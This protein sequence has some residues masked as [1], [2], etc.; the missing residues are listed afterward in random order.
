MFITLF[1]LGAC[2]Q[3]YVAPKSIEMALRGFLSYTLSAASPA[4]FRGGKCK[5]NSDCTQKTC[6]GTSTLQTQCI[7]GDCVCPNL[8]YFHT[9]LDPGLQAEPTPGR[10]K[11]V[12]ASA[13]IWTEPN[14]GKIG[15][16]VYPDAT[17]KIETVALATGIALLVFS[18]GLAFGARGALN[19]Y[20]L[21]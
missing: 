5:S 2:N 13:P 18:A 4:V 19:K 14:W 11:V 12:D 1:L 9:A 8:A 7:N 10:F 3:I 21:L 6:G 17:K 15:I 20:H 16:T